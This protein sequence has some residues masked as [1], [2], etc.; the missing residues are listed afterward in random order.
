MLKPELASEKPVI[1]RDENGRLLPDQPSL[2]PNGRPK[3]SFSIKTQIIKRL[4]SNPEEVKNIIDYLLTKEQALLFQ[5]ID[6]RPQQ[7]VTSQ[8]ERLSLPIIGMQIIDES[9]PGT[10]SANDRVSEQKPETNPSD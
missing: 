3:G 10:I 4:E 5:M 7:D 8:G 9:N 6:G 1:K 2:N